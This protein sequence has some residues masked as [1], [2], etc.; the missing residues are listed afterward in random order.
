MPGASRS[1]CLG[2]ME[3]SPAAGPA[4]DGGTGGDGGFWPFG[5]VKP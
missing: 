4:W 2:Q 1:G 3:V 5:G